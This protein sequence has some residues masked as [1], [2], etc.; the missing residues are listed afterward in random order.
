MLGETG[1]QQNR[2]K[3]TRKWY[4]N[5]FREGIYTTPYC[6]CVQAEGKKTSGYFAL[7]ILASYH[8]SYACN[9]AQIMKSVAKINH[10]I[11]SN[12]I[13]AISPLGI[14]FFFFISEIF[15]IFF[16]LFYCCICVEVKYHNCQRLCVGAWLK[17]L[18]IL[19]MQTMSFIQVGTW[20]DY[21]L[22]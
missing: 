1:E 3:Q 5:N 9:A 8:L 6:L 16:P 13:K 22:V 11:L 12:Q 17:Y 14:S 10:W 18:H 7:L 20:R 15:W 2:T 21:L 4:R 19:C